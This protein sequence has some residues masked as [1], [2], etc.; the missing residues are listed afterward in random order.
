MVFFSLGAFAQQGPLTCRL[1]TKASLSTDLGSPIGTIKIPFHATSYQ[2]VKVDFSQGQ[3]ITK[4]DSLQLAMVVMGR[5]I[6]FNSNDTADRKQGNA[7]FNSYMKDYMSRCDTFNF[8]HLSFSPQISF[9]GI[10]EAAGLLYS[11]YFVLPQEVIHSPVGSS[12]K[13]S[14]ILEGSHFNTEFRIDSA[15]DD[16]LRLCIH[17]IFSVAAKGVFLQVGCQE[18]LKGQIDAILYYSRE[19]LLGHGKTDIRASG[20]LKSPNYPFTLK[21]KLTGTYQHTGEIVGTADPNK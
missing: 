13:D 11:R 7:A 20:T 14:V 17:S 5:H 12:W 21:M 16:T 2:T 4:D 15:Y 9:W 3:S 19:G 6:N 8:N 1:L 18:N 10:G